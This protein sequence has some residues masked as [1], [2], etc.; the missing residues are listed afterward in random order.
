MG[1]AANTSV[2]D[3]ADGEAGS[4]AGQTDGQTGAELEEG[5]VQGHDLAEAVGNENRHDETVD[6]N[7]TSHND[8]N[9]VCGTLR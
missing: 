8:G 4:K 5:C 2:T 6:T 9:N 1:G 7:D 3:N